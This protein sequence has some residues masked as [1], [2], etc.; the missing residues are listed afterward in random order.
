MT[1][2]TTEPAHGT[3]AAHPDLGPVGIW[4][5]GFDMQSPTELS[6]TVGELDELGFG[7]VWFG[8]AY[9]REAFTQAQL[10]LR[11]SRRMVIATGIANIWARD[12]MACNAAT[13]T[14]A[15]AHPGRFLLGLG[16]SHQ[17]LVQR[18]RGHD[19]ARPVAAMRS[20]LAAMDKAPYTAWDAAG[21]RPARVLAALGP[22]M[23]A[24][25]RDQADG[26]HPYLS[27]PEHTAMARDVLGPDKLLAPEVSCVLTDDEDVW[28]RR[29]HAHLELYTGLPNYVGNWKRLGFTDDDTVRGGSDRLKEALVCRGIEATLKAVREHHEAGA[30]HVCVQVLGESTFSAPVADWRVLGEAIR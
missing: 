23:L 20:Y 26:S 2:T 15:S 24:A 16:V 9:G 13:R 22:G 5:V 8:E 21:P 3:P 27:L 17:P 29:A 1:R 30:D 25:A 18:M 6:E 19:Y 28:R 7:A 10:L 11:A 12:A 14:L 4:T